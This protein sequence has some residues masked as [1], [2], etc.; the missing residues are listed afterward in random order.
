MVNDGKLTKM[1]GTEDNIH[2]GPNVAALP[3]P[4]SRLHAFLR[5]VV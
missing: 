4:T 2:E 5:D 3:Q 1:K